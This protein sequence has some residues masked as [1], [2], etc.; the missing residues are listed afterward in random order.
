MKQQYLLRA[1][2]CSLTLFLCAS[3]NPTTQAQFIADVESGAAFGGPYNRIKISTESG[4]EFN[5]FGGEFKVRPNAFVRLRAGYTIAKRHTIIGLVA[6][7]TIFS[8]TEGYNQN[9]EYQGINF[10]SSLPLEVRYIFNSYRLTYR[11]HLVEKENITFALG[12]TAKIRQ[13]S[14]R[15]SN[16]QVSSINTNLGFVP[17]INIYLNWRPI[18]KLAIILEGDGLAVPQGRAEDFFVGAAYYVTDNLAIKGGYRLLEGGGTNP[19]SIVFTFLHFASVGL[20]WGM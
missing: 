7:L 11:F 6:P 9:I 15:L 20:T 13:A 18:D 16:E 1:L 3:F 8:N 12:A 4:T 19:E 2:V 14:V 10:S 17:I 5:A